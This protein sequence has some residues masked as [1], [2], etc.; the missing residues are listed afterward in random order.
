MEAVQTERKRS[1]GV[2]PRPR[3]LKHCWPLG[4]G[5]RLGGLL[6]KVPREAGSK[7]RVLFLIG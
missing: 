3:S 5:K 1:G 7:K 2:V 6:P 4:E